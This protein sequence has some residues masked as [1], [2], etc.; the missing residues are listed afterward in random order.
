MSRT[1]AKMVTAAKR[2]RSKALIVVAL[3]DCGD[4]P[5]AAY[6]QRMSSGFSVFALALETRQ[7]FSVIGK[8]RYLKQ[9][10]DD[11]NN[12]TL[13][14]AGHVPLLITPASVAHVESPRAAATAMKERFRRVCIHVDEKGR[15]T[16]H[17]PPLEA[18]PVDITDPELKDKFEQ[19]HAKLG[20]MPAGTPPSHDKVNADAISLDCFVVKSNHPSAKRKANFEQS[21]GKRPQS[22]KKDSIDA[23][24]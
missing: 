7:H 15:A 12:D 1:V 13:A 16:P 24:N 11:Y 10:F 14:I 8:A 22:D 9:A 3:G 20:P 4:V 5:L 2:G 6:K 17:V 19:L 21:D 18:W 23:N